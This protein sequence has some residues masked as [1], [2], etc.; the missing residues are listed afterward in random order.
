[1]P[2]DER[3][4]PSE[5]PKSFSLSLGS[6]K[7]KSSPL[8]RKP[9]TASNGVKRPHTSLHDSDDEDGISH[10]S[11]TE[12][13]SSFD[14]TAGGAIAVNGVEKKS[15][16][17]VIP[18][19]N[20]RNWREESRRKRGRNLL[21][22]EVQQA[23][24]QKAVGSD[25]EVVN[26]APPAFGLSFAHRAND[27]DT[28]VE[29]VGPGIKDE[30]P[31]EDHP[32]KPKTDDELALEA[33]MSNGDSR[34][35]NLVLP[36]V[37]SQEDGPDNGFGMNEDDAFR[38]DVD[39]RPESATLDQYAAVPVEEFGA[40]LLRGMGWKEGDVVGKRKDQISKPRLIERRPALL[41]IGAKEVPGGLGDSTEL[42]AW[43]KAA[44]GKRKVD[45]TYNP[46]LLQNQKTGEMVSEEELKGRVEEGKR[47]EEDKSVRRNGE[48]DWRERRDRN[49]KSDRERKE[50]GGR[51]SRDRDSDR[52][53]RRRRDR[54][55][56]PDRDNDGGGSGKNSRHSADRSSSRRE[57]ESRSSDSRHSSRR[58]DEE[59]DGDGGSH[60]RER[61]RDRRR[62]IPA[63]DDD[64]YGSSRSPSTSKRGHGEEHRHHRERSDHDDSRKEHRRRRQE[65]Y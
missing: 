30:A 35:T 2:T 54:D 47:L 39:S 55:R 21:P 13:V 44:R 53:E 6:S 16:S 22:Q 34:K 64:R 20:N 10:H 25:V 8:S 57:G 12:L 11:Q 42:G 58:R 46:V 37:T 51:S 27:K 14:H 63:D 65:V 52:E 41:G 1:M 5:P 38:F 62:T 29:D 23:S 3:N 28:A 59:D 9:L 48:D 50:R 56:G 19:Q 26:G 4:N 49:L 24:Q 40:A 17:L 36:A 31:G 7:P 18:K 15:E 45:K 43:G 32:V 33:L 60:H 61:E